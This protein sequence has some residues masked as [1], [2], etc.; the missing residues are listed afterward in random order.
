MTL[1]P[2]PNR[3]V[4]GRRGE[5]YPDYKC[6]S[7]CSVP[8]C[9]RFSDHAHHIWRRSFLSGPYAWVLLWNDVEMG[10]LTGLC[11]KH[12]EEVT[13]GET[14]IKLMRDGTLHWFAKVDNIAG[15][16]GELF[17][18]PP[19]RGTCP[20]AAEDNEPVGPAHAETCPTCKRTIKKT[21]GKREPARNRAR[22]S[23][24]VP[25]DEREN[26]ADVLDTLLEECGKLF[27]HDI[28]KK[29]RYFTA[30]Q[31]LALVVQHGAR[32]VRSEDIGGR[33]EGEE[34]EGVGVPEGSDR[35]RTPERVDGGPFQDGPDGG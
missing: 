33:S 15:D 9:S 35:V 14:M 16:C 6:A 26:G 32:M 1:L 7:V 25:Q 29:M 4:L 21:E 27:G 17:P 5:L 10:N 11:W 34:V 31:A 13:K 8:G 18:Q 20:A 24:H 12:H 23:I 28:D 19:R 2:H 30:A 3:D 22:W